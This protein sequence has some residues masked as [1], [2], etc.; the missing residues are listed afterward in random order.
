M[1]I[2][3]EADFRSIKTSQ[4]A[5]APTRQE[6]KSGGGE[7]F[8]SSLARARDAEAADPSDTSPDPSATVV[9]LPFPPPI[10]EPAIALEA[11]AA[12]AA[13]AQPPG[14]DAAAEILESEIVVDRQ[15]VREGVEVQAQGAD[16][17]AVADMDAARAPAVLA[18]TTNTPEASELSAT[19]TTS[20]AAA[21]QEAGKIA[22]QTSAQAAD[23]SRAAVTGPATAPDDSVAA[24]AIVAA[25]ASP[26]T[27]IANAKAPD[28]QPIQRSEAPADPDAFALMAAGDEQAA[29][30]DTRLSDTGIAP[31]TDI[32]GKVMPLDTAS[33]N[34]TTATGTQTLAAVSAPAAPQAAGPAPTLIASAPAFAVVTASPSQIVDIV[35]E[36]ADDGQS[37]RV[38]VQLDPPELGRVSIDFKFDAQGLQHVTIT[39]ETPEAMR[40]LRQMHSELVQSLERHGIGSENL[41][42]QHQQ[43]GSPQSPPPNPFARAAALGD[44]GT[45]NAAITAS[46]DSIP[47]ARTL[48][49]GRLDIRI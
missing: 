21:T 6:G 2:A 7:A 36:T 32:T 15:I 27:A 41:S 4:A 13:A 23:S 35:A 8:A 14:A 44:A 31:L 49:G 22:A 18:T 39:S 28:S 11:E 45:G 25:V 17:K 9:A 29:A 16:L 1:A 10:T 12:I 43:Q 38:V 26:A 3:L 34:S 47:G 40:Q 20:N 48:P 42:F 37:D 33:L 30:L 19:G 5:E 24:P 46:I